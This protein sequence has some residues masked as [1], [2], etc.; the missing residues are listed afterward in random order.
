MKR[1]L[2]FTLIE[3]SIVISILAVLTTAGLAAF[4]NYSRTQSL[5]TAVYDLRTT[6]NLAKSRAFSQ[7]KPEQS[8]SPDIIEPCASQPLDGYRVLVS[9][10]NDSFE[11]DAI[12]AGNSY[13]I[14]SGNFPQN[15]TVSS[16]ATTSTSFF[17]P[18]ISGGVVGSGSV[19][20]TGYGQTR[21][22]VVDSIGTVK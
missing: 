21:T 18:V 4:V 6:L 17:F 7:V 11:M 3:I 2:G 1:N 13:K 10:T 16:G 12:C 8:I 22:I 15:I 9:E 5:Q 20:L 14:Q 19:A